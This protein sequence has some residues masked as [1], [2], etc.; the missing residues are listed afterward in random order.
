MT[1]LYLA[2]HGQTDWNKQ[3]RLQGWTDIAL[4]D[5]GREQ[6]RLLA[7]RMKNVS[8]DAIYTSTLSRTRET[9]GALEGRAP[10]ISVADLRER[11]M[12]EFEGFFVDGRDAQRQEQFTVRKHKSGDDL[13]GG[14]T[15]ETFRSRVCGA[16]NN[17]TSKHADGSVLLVG[18]GATNS[19]IVGY[20]LDL[21]LND[22]AKLWFANDD[23]YR[24][25]APDGRRGRVWKE[26]GGASSLRFWRE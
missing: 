13:G 17:I 21:T 6:A 22:I 8:L 5:L 19:M 24:I 3:K 14:E 11:S 25:E 2:R 23:L 26:I 7:K 18:H 16:V 20:F 4:N 9:A 1:T 12:G 15:I 10:I